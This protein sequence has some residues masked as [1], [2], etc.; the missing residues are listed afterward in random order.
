MG[1]QPPASLL[2]HRGA[3]PWQHH[4]RAFSGHKH[5][6]LVTVLASLGAALMR[7]LQML[8][9]HELLTVGWNIHLRCTTEH[10]QSRHT[11]GGFSLW[12]SSLW[13][14]FTL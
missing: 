14:N 9:L 10:V 5:Q 6:Q 2:D 3:C 1:S 7:V 12:S 4:V 11:A 8:L 13:S